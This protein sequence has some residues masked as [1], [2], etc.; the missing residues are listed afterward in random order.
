MLVL[1]RKAAPSRDQL[2][3]R[4][5]SALPERSVVSLRVGK[6]GHEMLNIST[7]LTS[8][9]SGHAVNHV[10]DSAVEACEQVGRRVANVHAY[11]CAVNGSAPL[12][13]TRPTPTLTARLAADA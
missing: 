8:R 7:A 1:E 4:V 10:R 11:V 3:A 12:Q 2:V 13:L 6:R 9:A 5:T